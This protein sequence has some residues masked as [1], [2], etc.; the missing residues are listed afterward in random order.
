ME[1]LWQTLKA[2]SLIAKD[3]KLPGDDDDAPW[4]TRLMLGVSAWIAALFLLGFFALALRDALE[5]VAVSAILG[6][7]CIVAALW[8][9]RQDSLHEFVRQ[10]AFALSIAGQALLAFSIARAL[11]WRDNREA[12]LLLIAAVQWALWWLEDY[13]P[14]R[15]FCAFCGWILLLWLFAPMHLTFWYPAMALVLLT[16]TLFLEVRPGPFRARFAALTWSLLPIVAWQAMT[17]RNP[18]FIFFDNSELNSWS[19]YGVAGIIS[20]TWVIAVLRTRKQRPEWTLLHELL[21]LAL[22]TALCIASP[23]IGLPLTIIW[24]AFAVQHWLAFGIGVATL[25]FAIAQWYYALHIT[26][27]QKSLLLLA[28]GVAVLLLRLVLRKFQSQEGIVS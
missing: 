3:A 15:V 9:L 1:S 28:A 5:I 13:V 18:E 19:L 14:H 21:L 11:E 17:F 22:G 20:A 7:I 8:V 10:G 25:L 27:L 16:S 24:C 23:E 12:I 6:I 2:Q 26:L 4:Y